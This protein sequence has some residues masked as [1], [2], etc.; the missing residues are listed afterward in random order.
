M[1]ELDLRQK[2][3]EL[4]PNSPAQVDILNDYIRDVRNNSPTHAFELASESAQLAKT[5]GY[6]NGEARANLHLAFC[7]LETGAFR[8]AFPFLQ[9]AATL[10]KQTET[11]GGL[12]DT[13]NST[14][15]A[16][17]YLGEFQPALD[18]FTEAHALAVT[19][20]DNRRQSR[21][22][23]NIAEAHRNLGNYAAAMETYL[24]SVKVSEEIGDEDNAGRVFGNIGSLHELL[25]DYTAALEYHFKSHAIIERQDNKRN[26]MQVLYNI[27]TVLLKLGETGSALD[28]FFKQFRLAEELGDLYVKAL[29]QQSI[30]IT[31]YRT[32]NLT[33]ALRYLMQSLA[34]SESIGDR[35][36]ETVTRIALG[37]IYRDLNEPH[38]AE[39]IYRKAL[40]LAEKT[41]HKAHSA[42]AYYYLGSLYLEGQNYAGAETE[43]AQSLAIAE[44]I[45]HKEILST[46]HHAF[47]ELHKRI[48]NFDQSLR[49]QKKYLR[50]NEELF[51]SATQRN[52]QSLIVNFELESARKEL[53][54]IQQEWVI[55]EAVLHK[56][57][58]RSNALLQSTKNT[59]AKMGNIITEE[60]ESPIVMVRT[61]GAFQVM[62]NGRDIS[63]KE[64][65][66][67]KARDA[68]KILLIHHGNALSNEE[69]AEYLWGDT[70]TKNAEIKN[71]ETS[72][73]TTIS[74]L[75][76]ALEPTLEAHKPS[77]FLKSKDKSYTLALG[78]KATIDFMEFETHI[79]AA[80]KLTSDEPKKIESYEAA[81]RFYTGEFLTEDKQETWSAFKRETLREMATEANLFLAES[82]LR[83]QVFNDVVMY[84]NRLLRDDATFE[85]AYCL[86]LTALRDSGQL[87]EAK[88][89]YA[90]SV[91]AFKKELGIPVPKSIVK[92][93]EGS[94]TP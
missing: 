50:L 73:T 32:S 11:T 24:A 7:K 52:T 6:T 68:F 71:T 22:L 87:S 55:D 30:G 67:K 64:W 39:E 62:I 27:G 12:V 45:G 23:N 66:R 58:E 93:L 53:Q 84:A 56:A 69:L 36:G 46:A 54:P 15:I 26:Q 18:C 77:R 80:R 43:L 19:M 1:T 91:A 92:I 42:E 74:A 86:A 49:H 14:G 94:S 33:S 90:E 35:R 72:L 57:R 75:R 3:S 51:G 70:D 61:L 89:L 48:G 4:E 25:G 17:I 38:R 82:A 59:A 88:K 10:Y 21:C 76:K 83:R 16:H 47:A 28:Y 8:D 20:S 31:Y 13:L 65:G 78:E 44:E 9:T 37:H 41:Q 5:I 85:K 2:Q 60:Q 34:I 40:A 81:L 29:S 79:H 63:L